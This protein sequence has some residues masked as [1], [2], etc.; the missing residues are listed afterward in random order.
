MIDAIETALDLN[1]GELNLEREVLRDYGNMSAPTV[2]FVLERLLERG[3]PEQGDDDRLR[4]GLHLRR[5]AARSRV[6]LNIV[7]LALVTVQRLGELWLS[8]RNT[9][10]LLAQGA[11]EHAPGHYPLIV[12]VHAAVA[13]GLVVARAEPRRSTASGWHVRPD[14]ARAHLGAGVARAALDDADH[15]PSRRAARSAAAPTASSITPI[16]S[17]VVAEIAV[18]PLVFG[19]WQVA[20]IFSLLNA[21]VLAIRIRAENAALRPLSFACGLASSR[22]YRGSLLDIARCL[23]LGPNG[24]GPRDFW[25]S[26]G[27]SVAEIAGHRERIEPEVKSLG[28]ELVRVAMIGGTSDPTLQVMAE[29]PDTRQL[30]LADCEIDFAAPVRA[31]RRSTTRSRAATGSRSARP[32]STG[33]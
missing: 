26:S 20:L 9:R 5:D 13:C 32:A 24:S 12:A 15:R 11:R 7:I 31:A 25:I 21:A 4:S 10:R 22:L 1:Q 8:N 29:R 30:D 19:L 27:V 17:V 14:R 28:Y 33:R 2:L 23:R 3:L 18:L 6:I 16:I